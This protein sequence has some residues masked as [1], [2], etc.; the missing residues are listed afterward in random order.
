MLGSRRNPLASELSPISLYDL[1][2]G[3][4]D[5]GRGTRSASRCRQPSGI[6]GTERHRRAS[7]RR[8][9]GKPA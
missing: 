5:F 1:P 9:D 4:I 7:H 2:M 3:L 6:A 8:G